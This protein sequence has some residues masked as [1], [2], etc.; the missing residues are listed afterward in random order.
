MPKPDIINGNITK[1][2]IQL[3][4][5][6]TIGLL[7][8]TGFNIVDTMFVGRISADALAAV[9]MTFPIIFL[10]IALA[11]GVGVGTMSLVARKIGQG[12]KEHAGIAAE[13]SFLIALV[14]GISFIILG[15][16]FTEPLFKLMG[17]GDA[18]LPIALSY[19]HPIYIGI[20]FMFLAFASTS[21][22]R[23]AGDMKT[24]MKVMILVTILNVFL[25]WILIFGKG[26]IPAMGVPGAAWATVISRTVA[27]VYIFSH[28]LF[29][30]NL[31]PMRLKY[32]RPDMNVIKKI[33]SVGIPTSL[34]N[35][36]LSISMFF[37]FRL[38]SVFG[39]ATIA[40]YGLGFRIDSVAFMAIFGIASATVTFVGQNTGA[41]QMKRAVKATWTAAR[42][43]VLLMGFLGVAFFIFRRAFAGLFTS[44]SLII[45]ATSEYI[46]LV[47]LTYFSVALGVVTM[48]S[49]QGMGRGM[50]L[51]LM[52]ILRFFVIMLPLSYILSVVAGLGATGIW[53]GIAIA[54]I[55]VGIVEGI[56]FWRSTRI[57]RS[58]KT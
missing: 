30:Q 50:P 20:V 28:L 35:V 42:M 33:L 43:A 22:L 25:D 18:L 2:L 56:W 57:T 49:F 26:P 24:P 37:M 55:V 4:W 6:I 58:D 21:T 31:L 41:K 12:K 13:Q 38:A 46:L 44:D 51:L 15:F 17:A 3:S 53:A 11:S 7:M 23:G 39:P 36:S 8:Q 5:P 32:I 9:S 29:R 34:S 54:N 47:S 1:T 52:T 27:F 48:S 14:L 16:L 45:A 19:M 10:F 40:A